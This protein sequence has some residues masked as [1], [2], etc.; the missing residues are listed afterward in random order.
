MIRKDLWITV[1]MTGG[2]GCDCLGVMLW[3]S[4][5][6]RNIPIKYAKYLLNH[7]PVHQ[8][9]QSHTKHVECMA[10]IFGIYCSIY[11]EIEP[12]VKV[13]CIHVA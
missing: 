9:L 4:F 3:G 5:S 2:G 12:L 10:E 6:V 1:T 11:M 8:R 7:T 13:S